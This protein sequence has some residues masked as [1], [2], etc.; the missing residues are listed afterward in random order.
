MNLL[1]NRLLWLV[2]VGHFGIDI[3]TNL[4]PMMFPFF[5]V[6]Y[7]LDYTRV[8]LL[9]TMFSATSSLSQPFFGYLADK[10]GGRLLAPLG[11]LWT[12]CFMATVGFIPDY[13]TLLVVMLLGGLGSGAFHP[14]GAMNAA[15][16]GG[17]RKGSAVSVFMLGGNAGYAVG[18][19][20]GAAL[21]SAYGLKGITL[22]LVPGVL[23]A[24]F[25]YRAMAAVESHRQSVVT[26]SSAQGKAKPIAVVAIVS[27]ILIIMLRSWTMSGL[28]AFLALFYQEKGISIETA[29]QVLFIALISLAIG[30]LLGGFLS[31]VVGRRRVTFFALLGQAVFAFLFLQVTP[32]YSAAVAVPLGL[33][34]G[35]AWAIT[36]VMAQDMM[37]R[38]QGMASGLTLGLA[39][40]TSAVG[41]AI[42]GSLADNFGLSNSLTVL[43]AL[44][45]V[46]AILCFNLPPDRSRAKVTELS[47]A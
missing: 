28:N 38:N 9:S 37:P 22:L 20:I 5:V 44:P 41:V 18:P 46:A 43:T 2:S 23:M 25:L 36:I 40:V 10:F 8:G 32:P 6:M 11:I 47:R 15:M 29:S 35:A 7:D 26:R 27:L 3:S 21:L 13:T 1:R 12:A 33:L 42:T 19:V 34:T 24:L 31:D 4:T 39:F 14:Q 30:S 45:V 17:E 16:I